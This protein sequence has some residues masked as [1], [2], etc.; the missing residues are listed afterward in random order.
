MVIGKTIDN[1]LLELKKKKIVDYIV[2][3][4][5]QITKIR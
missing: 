4:H 5:N 1:I 2:Y 3:K